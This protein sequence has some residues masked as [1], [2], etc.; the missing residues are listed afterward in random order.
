M[1]KYDR[2]NT[3]FL[4]GLVLYICVE[5]IRIGPG[6]LSNPGSSPHIIFEL[7]SREAGFQAIPMP[8]PSV[9]AAAMTAVL[10]GH[11][12]ISLS[13]PTG[14]EA[15]LRI[16]AVAQD[17]RTEILPEVPTLTEIGYAVYPI[18]SA[19]GTPKGLQKRSLIKSAGPIRKP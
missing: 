11:A 10:G 15:Q 12:D 5:S 7:F 17:G 18:I 4:V 3:L 9:S 13:G 19:F 6:S 8:Y 16:L 14:L 2:M 1:S